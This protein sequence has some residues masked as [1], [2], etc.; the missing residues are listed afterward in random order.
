[1]KKPC[2]A[3][4]K[5]TKKEVPGH[6]ETLVFVGKSKKIVPLGEKKFPQ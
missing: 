6:A 5:K 3:L 1:M 2:P 4:P